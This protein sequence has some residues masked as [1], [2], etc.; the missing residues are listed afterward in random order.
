M[1]S[2]FFC[3][4]FCNADDKQE[5][6]IDMRKS[7]RSSSMIARN[8]R[9][10]R[11]EMGSDNREY[12]VDYFLY[13]VN[14]DTDSNF[15]KKQMGLSTNR[16]RVNE[17]PNFYFSTRADSTGKVNNKFNC[18]KFILIY[19]LISDHQKFTNK[20]AQISMSTANKKKK[21]DHQEQ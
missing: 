14:K 5:M 10:R 21:T 12:V 16:G 13:K 1:S 20:R 11:I 4:N 7:I 18:I 6:E 19:S 2:L 15:S 3:G 8:S 17:E 9:D